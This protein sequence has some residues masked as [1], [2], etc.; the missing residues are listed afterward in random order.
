M[1]FFGALPVYMSNI[2]PSGLCAFVSIKA[3][4]R[5]TQLIKIEPQLQNQAIGEKSW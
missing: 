3:K 2:Y 4:L 1:Q 5:A